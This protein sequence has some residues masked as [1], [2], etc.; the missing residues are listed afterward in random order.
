MDFSELKKIIQTKGTEQ[1]LQQLKNNWM[2]T[3]DPMISFL[4]HHGEWSEN[5][6]TDQECKQPSALWQKIV[7]KSHQG[8]GKAIRA[9]NMR[10][11]KDFVPLNM[12]YPA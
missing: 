10:M 7:A 12:A 9:T 3:D 1:A 5:G 4:K 8:R 11:V 6:C 2:E